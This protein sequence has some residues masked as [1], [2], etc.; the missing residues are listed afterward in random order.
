ML[1]TQLE[2]QKKNPSRFNL[3]INGEFVA[4]IS[5]TTLAKYTLYEGK[6]IDSEVLKE[7]LYVELRQRFLERLVGY[8][9]K[10]PRSIS[11]AR[12]YLKNTEYKKKDI[13]FDSDQDIDFEKMYDEVVNQLIEN[14]LLNDKEYATLFVQSRLRSKPRGKDILVSELIG[15]GIDINLARDVVEDLVEDE[16]SLLE[17]TFRKRYKDTKLDLKDSKQVN[18]LL[19]KGFRYDLIKEYASNE[20]EE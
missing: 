18:Y 5:A 15:K 1:I 10:S 4:G 6:S 12:S 8:I 14:R 13:W 3:Y 11:Q 16:M 20:F 7:V 17:D 9:T 2:I 19:R